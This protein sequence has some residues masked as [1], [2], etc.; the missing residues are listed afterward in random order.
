MSSHYFAVIPA[1][2]SGRRFGAPLPKQYLLLNGQPLICHTIRA[3]LADMRIHQIIVVLS[4]EDDDWSDACL[5]N[6]SADRVRVA[7]VGGE[8]RAESVL[9]GINWLRDFVD[10]KNEDWMLVHDAARPCLSGVQLARLIESLAN[11]AIGGLLAIPVADTVKRATNENRVES[12]V[13]RRQL[14]QAQTPQMFRIG[15][16]QEALNAVDLS[17]ATDESAAMEAQGHRPKLVLG[18]LSNLKVTY[19]EDLALASA[20]LAYPLTSE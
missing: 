14:W 9:N 16:L 5:P 4:P 3:L 12:T 15:L 13:D 17:S 19:P 7:R 11:D 6:G 8:T 1:A 20:I 10:V 2:G 18:G